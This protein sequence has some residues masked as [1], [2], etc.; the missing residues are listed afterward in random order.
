M[1]SQT[2]TVVIEML[3]QAGYKY[4]K[5]RRCVIEVLLDSEHNHLSTPE[6]VEQVLENDSSIGRM[7]V[8]RTLDLFTR[9]GLIRPVFQGSINA[10]YA[11]M[12]DGHHHHIV[13]Q[14]CGKVIHFDE[15]QL[16]DLAR[17]L[18]QKYNCLI[19]GHTLEFFGYCAA[20]LPNIP[21]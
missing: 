10:R 19:R 13:C 16:D 9:L 8:Y 18:E 14:N 15:C 7:T 12:V 17:Q 5:P 21:T 3:R 1:K 20:C 11:L 4:T 2:E 6:I